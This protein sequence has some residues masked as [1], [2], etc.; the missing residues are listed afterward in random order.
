MLAEGFENPAAVYGKR[1]S[2]Q[3][4]ASLLHV[5]CIPS[6][7]RASDAVASSLPSSPSVTILEGHPDAAASAAMTA[8]YCTSL[9]STARFDRVCRLRARSRLMRRLSSTLCFSSPPS[10]SSAAMRASQFS[11]CVHPPIHA[12]QRREQHG[13][14]VGRS[15]AHPTRPAACICSKSL[16]MHDRELTAQCVQTGQCA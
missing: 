10:S 7:P 3:P 15:A 6:L 9:I 1:T 13:R 2:S 8:S 12:L 5:A 16:C 14:H 4:E 11:H